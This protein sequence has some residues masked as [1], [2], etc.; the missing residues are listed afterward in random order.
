MKFSR[1]LRG[2]D[3]PG[4]IEKKKRWANKNYTKWV[5]SL[6]CVNCGMDDDTVVAHHLKHRYA[7]YSGGGVALKA[8][9]FFTM[10]LCFTCHDKAHNGEDDILDWQ[11]QFIFKT[12]D[13]AFRIGIL[14][15][16][17]NWQTEPRLFGEDLDD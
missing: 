15:Y 7:P 14:D 1:E 6:P 17:E 5:A 3:R 8:N 9:D 12:L 16:V 10:P 4:P 2:P 13:A 11:A